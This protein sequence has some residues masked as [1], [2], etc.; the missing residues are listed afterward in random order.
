MVY[1]GSFAKIHFILIGVEFCNFFKRLD[2]VV[3]L[4]PGD[5]ITIVLGINPI[6]Q[7]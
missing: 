3:S 4:I 7:H 6:S 5:R 1:E 2:V